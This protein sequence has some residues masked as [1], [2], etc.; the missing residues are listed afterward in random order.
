MTCRSASQ[1][2]A[3]SQVLE[4]EEEGGAWGPLNQL[5]SMLDKG[6]ISQA[7]YDSTKAG[8]LA[9]TPAQHVACYVLACE[10][11]LVQRGR[12]VHSLALCGI[13]V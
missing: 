11:S 1:A 2:S 9:R 3:S 10:T 6:L 13:A 5:K 8:I 4:P 12:N 7:E